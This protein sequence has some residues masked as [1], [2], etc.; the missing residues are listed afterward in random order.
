M[1]PDTFRCMKPVQQE[2]K[3]IKA[4]TRNF[5]LV[6]FFAKKYRIGPFFAK[7]Y[8]FLSEKRAH[9][10]ELAGAPAGRN[11]SRAR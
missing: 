9:I 5:G 10:V 6:F 11:R 3:K 7:F 4:K 1:P 8:V 2:S